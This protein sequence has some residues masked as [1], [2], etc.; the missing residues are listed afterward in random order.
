MPERGLSR[1][2]SAPDH[3]APTAQPIGRTTPKV[4]MPRM[5]LFWFE[6]QSTFFAIRFERSAISR[7]I[8]MYSKMMSTAARCRRRSEALAAQMCMGGPLVPD[9][10]RQR[11]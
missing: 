4:I 7:L 6:S 5:R 11:V 1:F 9:A 10:P 8:A 2:P 3:Q